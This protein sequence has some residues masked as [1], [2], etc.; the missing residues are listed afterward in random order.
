MFNWELI[1]NNA[2]R[3]ANQIYKQK[4]YLMPYKYYQVKT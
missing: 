1:S 3:S 4:F 2:C